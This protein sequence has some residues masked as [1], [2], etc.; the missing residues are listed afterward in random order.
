MLSSPFE[1]NTKDDFSESKIVFVSDL[2]RDD[3]AGGAE[4]STDALLKTSTFGKVCFLRSRELTAQHIQQGT[5]KIWVFFN[6]TSMDLNLIPAIVANC[7][8]FIVEYDYKFCKFRSIE[9]HK[10]ET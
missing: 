1:N 8:Y 4:L 2:H 3:Y 9:K 10:A 6:F 5:Q 7:H